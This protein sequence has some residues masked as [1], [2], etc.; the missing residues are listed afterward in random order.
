MFPQNEMFFAKFSP[1]FSVIENINSEGKY[2]KR[3][4]PLE[5]RQNVFLNMSE[6]LMN[7]FCCFF[8]WGKTVFYFSRLF[9]ALLP[10]WPFLHISLTLSAEWGEWDKNIC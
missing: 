1:R 2:G 7:N 8:R 4:L 3:S 9:V 10:T 5:I 6:L